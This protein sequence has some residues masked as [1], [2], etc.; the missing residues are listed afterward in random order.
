MGVKGEPLVRCV[1]SEPHTITWEQTKQAID[2][3]M[4]GVI[5]EQQQFPVRPIPALCSS[6]VNAPHNVIV[7]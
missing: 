5:G 7:C 3:E 4:S 1:Y 2:A 6:K